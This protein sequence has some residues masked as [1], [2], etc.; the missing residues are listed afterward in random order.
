MADVAATSGEESES[1]SE[2]ISVG[3][4]YMALGDDEE[5]ILSDKEGENGDAESDESEEIYDDT[6][7]ADGDTTS[8]YIEIVMVV[9]DE[10]RRTSQLMSTFE[11]AEVT[12]IRATQIS[13]GEPCFVDV[14]DL[15][16]PL[17]M[18][19]REFM[20]RASPLVLR[21]EVGDR[22]NRRTNKK[23]KWIEFWCVREMTYPVTYPEAMIKKQ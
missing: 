5:D 15:T 21:R 11:A 8:E 19:K 1:S 20:M 3:E 22:I 12:S 6:A 7:D 14:S 17:L 2:E 4:E 10:D 18:A 16:D 9:R 23:E 13:Q